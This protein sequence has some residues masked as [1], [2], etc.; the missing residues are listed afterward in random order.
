MFR[1]YKETS[2]LKLDHSDWIRYHAT[3]EE[4]ALDVSISPNADLDGLVRFA[5]CHDE[6][7]YINIDGFA[8]D[9]EVAQ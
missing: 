3:N 2:G 4:Y 1:L 7:E 5:W 9:W 6:N 8:F